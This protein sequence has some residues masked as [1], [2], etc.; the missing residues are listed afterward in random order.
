MSGIFCCYEEGQSFWANCRFE[1]YFCVQG[2]LFS[3]NEIP[4]LKEKTYLY[5][6]KEVI[7]NR[8]ITTFNIGT[9]KPMSTN[10]KLTGWYKKNLQSIYNLF[11]N[12]ETGQLYQRWS[13]ITGKGWWSL[14]PVV[15][16]IAKWH[17]ESNL[18]QK[19]FKFYLDV[20]ES[21]LLSQIVGCKRYLVSCQTKGHME[22]TA[23]S[24]SKSRW[25]H[26]KW[27]TTRTNQSVQSPT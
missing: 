7:L 6:L 8:L 27:H 1:K 24:M 22:K 20:G 4:H 5:S 10:K 3:W 9:I 19:N 16:Q 23:R 25:L 13:A 11:S 15:G 14:Q 18:F 17:T 2:V 26:N 21:N 12:Y